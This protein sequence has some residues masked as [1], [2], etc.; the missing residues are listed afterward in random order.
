[1]IDGRFSFEP[2]LDVTH[3]D[4]VKGLEWDYVVVPDA[5]DT[6]YPGDPESRRRLHVAITRASYQ[7][8]LVAPGALTPILE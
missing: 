1:M 7:V 3:V 6:A 2:G 8:W 4:D 5:T